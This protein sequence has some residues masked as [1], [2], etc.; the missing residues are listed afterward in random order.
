M[1]NTLYIEPSAGIAGDMFLSALCH[2]ADA[3]DEIAQLP[4]RLNLPDARIEIQE[5]D[6]N[7]IHCQHVKVIDTGSDHHHH[8]HHRHLSDILSIIAEADL[9]DNAK[10]IA[11]TIFTIIGESESRIHMVPL[12][13]IHFHEVSGVDSILDIVGCAWLI[14]KLAI[15]RCYSDPVCV[16]F[17]HVDTQ[18]GRLPVPAPATADILQGIPTFKGDEAGE[19]ATPTGAAILKFLAPS[20]QP[21]PIITSRIAYGPG[22]K[23]FRSANVLR[24][25]LLEPTPIEAD[26]VWIIETNIDDMTPEFLGQDFQAGLMATGAKDFTLSATLMKKG[27]PGF[28]LSALSSD[29]CRDRVIEYILENTSSIGV[30]YYAAE[31]RV[32]E[33]RNLSIDTPEGAV[34]AKEVTKPSGA[35][36]TKLEFESLMKI[37]R[38]TNVPIQVLK[39]RIQ[40]S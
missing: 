15:D 37:A 23:D 2:L 27:R 9:P 17:G 39:N 24:L 13:R 30:R 31:R 6:K 11:K 8:H 35:K 28:I 4:Q 33:R 29:A 25:S 36:Q 1:A 22:Q 40:G 16:G 14:D 38:D 3:Y 7:G 19:R 12:E 18:H 26:L 34:L 20:F 32:L 5:L 21:P 10:H